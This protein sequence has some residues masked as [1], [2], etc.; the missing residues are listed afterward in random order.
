MP[1]NT[2]VV[3]QTMGVA[4]HACGSIST[5]SAAAAALIITAGFVPRV[6]RFHNIT[7]RISDEWFE[8]LD[9]EAAFAA[10]NGVLAKLD[11]D[12]GVT[13]T[14]YLAT[15]APA[16]ATAAALQASIVLMNAKLDADGGVTDTNYSALWNPPGS[17]AAQ[18]KTAI[19][20]VNA[21]LDADAG[22]TDTNYAATWNVVANSL[23]T[24]AAGTRT[25][26]KANGIVNN[27]DGTFTMNATA[28][29]ASKSFV[30][31]AIG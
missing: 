24:V 16:S 20:G 31:E 27:G 8:G 26:E 13:D 15:C 14:N 11:A 5:T 3:S 10:L 2:N 23:H 19:N 7:D 4:N 29:V 17:S 28:M 1:T 18:I 25:F 22:V 21:K 6:I 30:W 12:A 9:E